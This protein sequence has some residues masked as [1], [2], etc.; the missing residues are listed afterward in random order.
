M[1]NGVVIEAVAYEL[2]PHIISSLSLEEEFSANLEKLG[3]PLGSLEM[4]TGIKER[5]FW[6]LGTA[7]ST[8][9]TLAAQKVID[10]SGINP[11]EIGCIIS[12]SVSKDYLEPSVACLVHGNLKLS[13]HC[14][15]YDI[16][17]ACFGFVDGM[18]TIMM[19]LEAKNTQPAI[20]RLDWTNNWQKSV[21]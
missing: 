7:P 4:L 17:N 1:S 12:T 3:I 13:A 18:S 15:N 6:D 19:M 5:R 2:A 16:G 10:Q 21:S 20:S 11:D 14:R 9:A 8:V